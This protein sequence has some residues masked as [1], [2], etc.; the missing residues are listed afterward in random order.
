MKKY[1]R[2]KTKEQF[3]EVIKDRSKTWMWNSF[4]EDTCYLPE[5][6]SFI[7]LN[8]AIQLGYEEKPF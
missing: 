7:S 8:K 4:K 3:D 5:E 2:L 1:I 6:K